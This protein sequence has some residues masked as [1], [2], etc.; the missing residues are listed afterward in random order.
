MIH[1]LV[2]YS[3]VY[4]TDYTKMFMATGWFLVFLTVWVYFSWQSQK[5]FDLLDEAFNPV[6]KSPAWRHGGD[7]TSVSCE[8][9]LKISPGKRPPWPS[10][11]GSR[12]TAAPLRRDPRVELPLC[13]DLCVPERQYVFWWGSFL[14]WPHADC[15]P[16]G[17]WRQCQREVNRTVSTR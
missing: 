8:S 16:R 9:S 2:G 7:Q 13:L 15:S 14:P 6:L 5:I 3:C 12:T 10:D 1:R 11:T 4:F 17:P